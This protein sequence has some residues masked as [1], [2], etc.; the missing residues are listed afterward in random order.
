MALGRPGMR[1]STP[2]FNRVWRTVSGFDLK[3]LA[4]RGAGA[5]R[6]APN[7][8]KW[9]SHAK[10]VNLEPSKDGSAE[11]LTHVRNRGQRQG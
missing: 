11:E 9:V 3:F 7:R 5:S 4:D 8:R 10:G 6:G 1:M 2:A